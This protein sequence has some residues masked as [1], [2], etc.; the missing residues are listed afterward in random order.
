MTEENKLPVESLS[1]EPSSSA[2]KPIT[3]STREQNLKNNGVWA[4]FIMLGILTAIFLGLSS[5]AD[6][7]ST[8]VGTLFIPYIVLVFAILSVQNQQ[9]K[10]IEKALADENSLNEI[11]NQYQAI[12]AQVSI[13]ESSKIITYLKE[14]TK[15]PIRLA[16]RK[17]SVYMWKSE[18]TISFFACAPDDIRSISIADLKVYT[19]PVSQIEYFSK[20]GE[21]F[22]ENK[23]SG[24]GG[25]GSSIGGAVA[26][27]LIAG[28]TGAIIGSRKKVNEI[29]S[30]LITHDS[31]ETFLNYFVGNERHSLFFDHVAFQIFNDL[32]PEKEFSIV[33][34][35][36]SSEI[37]KNQISTN[38]Q[39]NV[40]DQLRELAKLRDEG[41][42]TENEFSE[43][44]KQL[45]DKTA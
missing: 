32:I 23:I 17:T 24:G 42:I 16:N 39:K 30:E 37:I 21:I 29:K 4:T 35:I 28:E 33:N 25:G 1:Q 31:R 43:K 41:I 5:A 2:S 9:N 13:P 22:R 20:Q 11:R 10:A 6:W 34:A 14:S 44:K 38:S 8:C 36:K 7:N 12:K 45:L 15:S 40:T 27:G 19:I 26:G 18:E 3:Q